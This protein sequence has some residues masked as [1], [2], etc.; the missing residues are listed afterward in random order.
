LFGV[1]IN[2]EQMFVFLFYN[3]NIEGEEEMYKIKAIKVAYIMTVIVVFI[4]VTTAVLTNLDK[5]LS[6]E[7]IKYTQ[8]NIEKGIMIDDLASEYSTQENKETFIA[9]VKKINKLDNVECIDK[10][11]LIIPVLKSQ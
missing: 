1:I 11:L 6:K 4:L 3:K 5:F 7:T 2:N 10:T 9:E 8:V